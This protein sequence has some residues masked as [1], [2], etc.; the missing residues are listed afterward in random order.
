MKRGWIV[1]V[2]A[3]AIVASFLIPYKLLSIWIG[4]MT[5]LI[6]GIVLLPIVAFLLIVFALAPNNLYFT[7]VDE[8]TAKFVTKGGEFNKALIQWKD[9]TFDNDWNVV[10][11]GTEKNGKVY[12]ESWHPFGGLRF[13]GIWPIWDIHLY[14]FQWTGVKENGEIDPHP[15][16]TLD[17]ILLKDD[18]YWLKVEKAEDKNLLPLEVAVFA[19]ISISNPYKARFAVQNWLEAAVN[20]TKPAIRDAVTIDIFE[21]LI[22]KM[23]TVGEGIYKMLE[24][25]KILQEFQK[26]YGVNVRKIEVKQINPP[27]ER[28]EDTLKKYLAEQEQKR[29]T[30]LAAAEEQRIKQVYGQIKKFGDLGRLLRALEAMEKSPL[31]TSLQVQAIPGLPELLRGVFG[32]APKAITAADFKTLK[33]LRKILRES[34]VKTKKR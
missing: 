6:L 17:Y 34:T 27:P 32:K 14:D 23:E 3:I 28:R 19:T 29:I 18:V 9:H 5:G 15:R 4:Q 30:T 11:N 1:F 8:G 10:P 31:A 12:K 13:Y 7:F 33:T 26:R 21:N 2:G 24:N 22:T 20:R 25:R 16:R